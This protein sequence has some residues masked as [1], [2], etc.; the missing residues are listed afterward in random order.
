[1]PS[2]GIE[3]DVELNIKTSISGDRD[4]N[5]ST[6]L[7]SCSRLDKR[8][9]IYLTQLMLSC[10]VIAFSISMLVAHPDCETSINYIPLLTFILGCWMPQPQMRSDS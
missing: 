9:F 1:M 6:Y 3:Y 10:I 7:N 2:V 8:V 5:R 4:F